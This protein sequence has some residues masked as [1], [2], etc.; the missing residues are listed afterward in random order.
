MHFVIETREIL[1][2]VLGI[3]I[4]RKGVQH[5]RLPRHPETYLFRVSFL[6]S[7]CK[8]HSENIKKRD[9]ET[10]ARRKTLRGKECR[11][12]RGKSRLGMSLFRASYLVFPVTLKCFCSGPR[13]SFRCHFGMFLFEITFSKNPTLFFKNLPKPRKFFPSKSY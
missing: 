8:V 11:A 10:S 1:K 6:F 2:R 13:I 9:A 5:D 3:N 4:P 12:T 7:L